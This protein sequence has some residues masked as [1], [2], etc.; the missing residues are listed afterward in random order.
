MPYHSPKELQPHFIMAN[1]FDHI[2]GLFNSTISK[3]INT[4]FNDKVKVNNEL[5]RMWN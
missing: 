2:Y 5:E 3:H 1:A 4:M